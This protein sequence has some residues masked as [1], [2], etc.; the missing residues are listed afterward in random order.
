MRALIAGAALWVVLSGCSSFPVADVRHSHAKVTLVSGARVVDVSAAG[1][2]SDYLK[3]V[4]GFSHL[5][6]GDR[7]VLV[8]QDSDSKPGWTDSGTGED[9]VVE[10]PAMRD[11]AEWTVAAESRVWFW[12]VSAWGFWAVEH[13]RGTTSVRRQSASTWALHVDIS[14]SWQPDVG[15]RLEVRLDHTFVGTPIPFDEF[16][17]QSPPPTSWWTR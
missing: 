8:V 10:I 1:G 4:T 16:R 2:A 14:G 12:K 11:R 3:Q 15:E 6:A 13:V 7:F 9:L 17:R 5:A